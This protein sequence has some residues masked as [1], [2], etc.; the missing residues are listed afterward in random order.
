MIYTHTHTFPA[1]IKRI[2]SEP[3]KWISRANRQRCVRT[4]YMYIYLYARISLLELQQWDLS[5]RSGYDFKFPPKD[6][7]RLIVRDIWRIHG[8]RD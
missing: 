5:A 8:D 2:K 3:P 7:W 1:R 6:L 4:Y